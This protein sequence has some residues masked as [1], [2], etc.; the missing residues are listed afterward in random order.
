[1]TPNIIRKQASRLIFRPGI[2]SIFCTPVHSLRPGYI[3]KRDTR[4]GGREGVWMLAR[5]EA[6]RRA[7]S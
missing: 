6:G 1:M 2:G 5:G 3:P 4:T 7:G